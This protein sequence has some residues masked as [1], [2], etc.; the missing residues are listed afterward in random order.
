VAVVRQPRPVVL[1]TSAALP[2]RAH[3]VRRGALVLVGEEC[4][5]TD[6]RALAAA[7]AEV[8]RVPTVVTAERRSIHLPA[9]LERL[10]DLGI[11]TVL[12]EPGP[13]LA[14]AML[15]ADAVDE[16][17]LHVARCALGAA[18]VPAVELAPDRFTTTDVR[19]VGEDLLVRARRQ[20]S[21]SSLA[22][23]R[24]RAVA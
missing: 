4:G 23:L 8:H 13:R 19:A 12:A 16:V 3:V 7:G 9:A 20:R 17:E 21:P 6:V 24:P 11:M 1:A 10:S 5:E 2:L 18:I 15:A 22:T 14:R